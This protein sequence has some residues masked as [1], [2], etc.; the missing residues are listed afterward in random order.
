MIRVM[1]ADDNEIIRDDI[2]EKL[3]SAGFAVSASLPSGAEAA[4]AYNPASTD[5]VLMDIEMESALAGIDAARNILAAY[6]DAAIIYLTSHDD[7]TMI[8]TAM[9]TGA[10]D[11]LVKGCGQDE[12]REHLEAAVAGDAKLDAR[13]RRL[14]M[15][16]YRRLSMSE[17]SLLYFIR[18]LSTLTNTERELIGC[19]L[20]G[21]KIKEIAARRHVEPVTVKSQVRTLLQK[22]GL[23]RTSEIASEIKALGIEHL[24]RS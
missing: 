11:F 23:S 21:M 24:F 12:L 4:A 6:P 1:I 18:H 22:F 2:R 9:A 15:S 16:E 19:F 7:D 3:E 10:R 20:D 8:I 17:Q 13:I 5:A 14:I